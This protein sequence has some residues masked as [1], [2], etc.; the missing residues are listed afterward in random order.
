MNLGHF[1][2]CSPLVLMLWIAS[3]ISDA[4]VFKSSK[5]LSHLTAGLPTCQVPSGL[6]RVNFLQG[7]CSC[8]LKNE[9]QPSQ[10]PYFDHLIYNLN[11]SGRDCWRKL[12]QMLTLILTWHK[13][14]KTQQIIIQVWNLKLN[15]CVL[16]QTISHPHN[17]VFND[18]LEE[19]KLSL[20][21]AVEARR[22]ARHQ[23]SH[24]L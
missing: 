4:H 22:V 7:F 3:P 10:P 5:E 14:Y 24:T 15:N 9:S 18:I 16:T 23:G 11:I 1:Y 17:L 21:Q 6:C 19:V 2:E 13:V 8:I 12:C 20:Q